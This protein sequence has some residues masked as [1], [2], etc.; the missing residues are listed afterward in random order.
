MRIPVWFV[1]SESIILPDVNVH[2]RVNIT[3]PTDIIME[4]EEFNVSQVLKWKSK[5]YH[6]RYSW[7][8]QT[9][10][11]LK[12]GIEQFVSPFM[13]EKVENTPSS[14]DSLTSN[15]AQRADAGVS[16]TQWSNSH[17]EPCGCSTMIHFL[18]IDFMV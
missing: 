4:K 6:G 7:H 10:T 12:I 14:S 11:R 9:W 15:T 5:Q 8:V 1:Q 18:F 16:R 2:K 13:V 3:C 17:A